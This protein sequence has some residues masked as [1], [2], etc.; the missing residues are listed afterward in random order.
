M[1]TIVYCPL[2]YVLLCQLVQIRMRLTCTSLVLVLVQSRLD[3]LFFN[4]AM[5]NT[6][7]CLVTPME[8]PIAPIQKTTEVE[9]I[10][11][12]IILHLLLPDQ[13]QHMQK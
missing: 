9:I 7:H 12:D 3:T 10:T 11:L 8:L 13:Y 5:V 4:K 6:D 2:A 1:L